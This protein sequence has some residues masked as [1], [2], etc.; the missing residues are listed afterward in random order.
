MITLRPMPTKLIVESI[1]KQQST[2]TGVWVSRRDEEP[3]QFALIIDPGNTQHKQNQIVILIEFHV[4]TS[5][6]FLGSPIT[7]IS[8]DDIIG[9]IEKREFYANIY[10]NL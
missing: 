10:P 2:T 9:T 6:L 7:I 3:T 1:F 4:G 5:L 8:E